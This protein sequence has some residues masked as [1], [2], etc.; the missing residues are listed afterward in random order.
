MRFQKATMHSEEGFPPTLC[1]L[2]KIGEL[3]TDMQETFWDVRFHLG[4]TT[5][6]NP[7]HE[8]CCL[9]KPEEKSRLPSVAAVQAPWE[10]DS[11]RAQKLLLSE[12]LLLG[13][14]N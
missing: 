9:G 3:N 4:S 7:V 5:H 8:C 10:E 14:R 12:L 13:M 6:S 1:P 11:L 2:N